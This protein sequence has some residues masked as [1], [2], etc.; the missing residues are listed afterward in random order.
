MVYF[1]LAIFIILLLF[2]AYL[3]LHFKQWS[4][5]RKVLIG[6]ILGVIFGSLMQLFYGYHDSVI[7]ES[8][9][10]FAIVGNGY[11]KLLQMIV[12]PLIFI[13]ILSAISKLHQNAASLGKMSFSVIFILLATT[14]IAAC[15]AIAVT[16]MFDLTSKG[17]IN[18]I[19]EQQRFSQ[20]LGNQHKVLTD[21]S[22]PQLILAFIP[23]NPFGDLA[24]L[25]STS[26]IGVVI[27]S[28]FLGISAL[29]LLKDNPE[30]GSKI[31][32]GIDVVQQWIMK[33]VRLVMQL[34]PYGVFAL[35][36]SL[37]SSSDLQSILKL[38]VFIVAS[39]VAIILMFIVHGLIILASG[40]SFVGYFKKISSVMAF[41]FTSR[42]SAASIPLNIET[43]V[44]QFKVPESIAGF[45]AS[46][47]ATIGQNGC[48]GIYPAM[49][50][51]MVAIG[52]GIPIDFH[53]M[54][55]LVCVV[56]L[57]SIGVAGVGGGATFAALMVLP[58]LGLPI[59]IVALLV[60]IEPLID[61]GRT[62]L[63]VSGS[64][65]SGIVTSKILKEQTV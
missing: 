38:G 53:F 62:A 13:S 41:A 42:S 60:S 59:E 61:M 26:I 64:M 12:M 46:F 21:L 25:S 9:Q 37:S 23:S 29:K 51:V 8:M 30:S 58:I 1:N 4:L 35:M 48:A 18:G 16:L 11:V 45:A 36:L 17:L 24:K 52:M 57:S 33:L 54:V 56:T 47:G 22:A 44:N 7:A 28:T 32:V 10:W 40:G 3:H 55:I 20:L 31:I 43:Q 5:S 2:L 65:V 50:A 27:F 14:F 49:L 39:Y 6:L 15:I 63:N 19:A 34:T